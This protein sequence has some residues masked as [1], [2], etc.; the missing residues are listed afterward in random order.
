MKIKLTPPISKMIWYK[1]IGSFIVRA[2][3]IQVFTV[4]N[5]DVAVTT[6]ITTNAM[7]FKT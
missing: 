7:K 3:V 5:A 1:L 2:R 4:A 6:T